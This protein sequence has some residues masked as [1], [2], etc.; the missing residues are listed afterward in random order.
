M[1]VSKERKE[2]EVMVITMHS[3]DKELSIQHIQ[4]V[5]AHSKPSKQE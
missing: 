2:A 3:F 5:Q 1:I 4:S